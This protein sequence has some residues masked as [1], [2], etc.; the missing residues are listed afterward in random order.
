MEREALLKRANEELQAKLKLRE[1][2]LFER[3]SEKSTNSKEQIESDAP[4]AKPKRKRG[5][6]RGAKEHGR[7]CQE[8]LPV[9]EEFVEL[10]QDQRCCPCCRLPLDG[11]CRN[12]GQSR[13]PMV[14][15]GS[16]V[17]V[18]HKQWAIDWIKKIGQH[19]ALNKKRLT[20]LNAPEFESAQQNLQQA[21]DVMAICCNQQL[22]EPKLY[23][24]F[25]KVLESLKRHWSGLVLFVAPPVNS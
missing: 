9:V 13:S 6:Q 24:A 25:R 8:N 16:F 12:R 1:R 10:A 19:Y 21:V 17:P 5:Q 3:H 23:N 11:L 7:K 22:D 2:Q 18:T 14:F 4:S 15:D 20:L